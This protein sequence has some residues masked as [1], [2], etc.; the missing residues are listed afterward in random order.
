VPAAVMACVCPRWLC[1]DAG[2]GWLWCSVATKSL[3][4]SAYIKLLLHAP[5]DPALRDQVLHIF[6]K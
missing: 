1:A 6:T 5:P 3:L 4:L 2:G